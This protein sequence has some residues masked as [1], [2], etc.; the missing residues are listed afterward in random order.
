MEVLQKFMEYGVQSKKSGQG[1]YVDGMVMYRA[2]FDAWIGY[3]VKTS[4]YGYIERSRKPTATFA[5]KTAWEVSI[6]GCWGHIYV[7]ME[8][9]EGSTC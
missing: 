4:D 7:C 6:A 3:V 9:G 1:Q 5:L 8:Y 2:R